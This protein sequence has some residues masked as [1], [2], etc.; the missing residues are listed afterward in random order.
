MVCRSSLGILSIPNFGNHLMDIAMDLVVVSLIPT[1]SPFNQG[2]TWP[3]NPHRLGGLKGQNKEKD[4]GRSL[5]SIPLLHNMINI[6]IHVLPYRTKFARICIF[7]NFLYFSN[8][9][10][11][12]PCP[13][14]NCKSNEV[15]SHAHV[16]LYIVSHAPTYFV[17]YK[18][19]KNDYTRLCSR[20][21]LH[22]S[23]HL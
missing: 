1:H 13:Q 2:I 19:L 22:W 10:V 21:L 23:L 12:M 14:N 20:L 9:F 5:E 11:N 18:G 3:L 17:G 15:F 4:L 7:C 8:V 16:H 6:I